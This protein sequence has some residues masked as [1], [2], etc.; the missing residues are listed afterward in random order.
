MLEADVYRDARGTFAETFNRGVF[1]REAGIDQEFVQENQSD[2]VRNV[3]RG[4]HYQVRQ[5]QGKLVGVI[6]GRVYDVAVDIRRSSPAFG[7]W[8]GVY[9]SEDEQRWVWIPPGF[10]HGFLVVS[11]R[12]KCH[13]KVT[14]YWAPEHE[15]CLVWNDPDLGI[16]WPIEGEP[17]LSAKDIAGMR[18]RDAEV[19]P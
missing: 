7:R 17:L 3:L 11:D 16:A 2:S 8:T 19:F 14:D 6:A 12:A 1:A 9:L 15:R 10:A 5:A 4:L 13:Y 18:L